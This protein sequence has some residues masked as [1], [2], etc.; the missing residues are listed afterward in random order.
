ML[1][2]VEKVSSMMN[3]EEAAAMSLICWEIADSIEPQYA[4]KLQAVA[5]WLQGVAEH[6]YDDTPWS[7]AW[8]HDHLVCVA[9]KDALAASL[10]RCRHLGNRQ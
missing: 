4:C 6:A 9:V 5:E 7:L 10:P 8:Y 3:P 2:R 1:A